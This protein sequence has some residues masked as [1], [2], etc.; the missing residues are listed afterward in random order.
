[1]SP[2]GEARGKRRGTQDSISQESPLTRAPAFPAPSLLPPRQARRAR[3]GVIRLTV[4]QRR[5]GPLQVPF[6]CWLEGGP[7]RTSSPARSEIVGKIQKRRQEQ[8]NTRRSRRA[9]WLAPSCR[10]GA[11]GFVCSA[12]NTGGKASAAKVSVLM[13]QLQQQVPPPPAPSRP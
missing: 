7:W 4:S 9:D 11:D 8:Q 13:S 5:S 3:R 12:V 6:A 10:H 2:K 1:M